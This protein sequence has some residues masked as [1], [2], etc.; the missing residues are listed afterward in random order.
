MSS[1]NII[2]TR[3][4]LLQLTHTMQQQALRIGLVPTMGYLHAG[5]LSLVEAAKKDCDRVVVSSF[6]NP[7]QF[8]PREDF[9]TYPR[10]E[11]RDVALCQEAG[12]DVFFA[13]DV[14]EL[15]PYGQD[16]TWV[17]LSHLSSLLCG[18]TRPGHF[19]GV[20]TVVAKLINLSHA[21]AAFF[22]QK[23]YQQL[24][25]V[26]RMVQDLGFDTQI[27]PCPI[28]R[29]NDGLAL[30]SRN[31]RLSP[32]AR[33]QAPALNK[34]L[35]AAHAAYAQACRDITQLKWEAKAALVFAPDIELEY[36]AIVDPDDLHSFDETAG[37]RAIMLI[38]GRLGG[39]RLIDNMRLD[40]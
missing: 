17:E 34:A 32:E 40:Q 26:Q 39:V 9:S 33:A 6:V 24:V 8:G 5:H 2:R 7:T 11:A 18:A 31:V 10:D 21:D 25:I 38:A 1:I 35:R 4:E 28:V 12:V 3:R 22:G 14:Q 20:C 37:Q 19:R 27:V 30:S 15:Y 23:D 13:P 29:E 16:C 36:I